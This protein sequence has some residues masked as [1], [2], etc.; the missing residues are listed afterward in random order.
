MR[1]KKPLGPIY[2]DGKGQVYRLLHPAGRSD[3]WL[4]RPLHKPGKQL[5]RPVRE[6]PQLPQLAGAR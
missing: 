2:V 5:R 4:T 1:D 3:Q 6:L